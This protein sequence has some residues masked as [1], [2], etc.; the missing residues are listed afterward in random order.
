MPWPLKQ[1]RAIFLDR[2]RKGGKA[3]AIRYMH[4][5]GYPKR[6]QKKRKQR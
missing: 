3:Y 4:A 2:K 5:H 1:E 6:K